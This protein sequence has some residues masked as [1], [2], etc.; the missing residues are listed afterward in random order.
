MC[1]NYTYSCCDCYKSHVIQRKIAE[2]DDPLKCPTCGGG[3]TYRDIEAP[4]LQSFVGCHKDE[5]T[6]T[7]PRK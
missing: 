7:G 6:K 2:R 4:S 5:Y 1:P 3:G